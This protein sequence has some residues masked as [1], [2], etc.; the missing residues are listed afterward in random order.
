M[1]DLD[2][3]ARGVPQSVH[4]RTSHHRRSHQHRCAVEAI[5]QTKDVVAVWGL[6]SMLLLM[7]SGIC[8]P[9]DSQRL[10]EEVHL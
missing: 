6:L 9:S 2:T 8:A 10:D 7:T 3:V 4:D 1:A 5:D